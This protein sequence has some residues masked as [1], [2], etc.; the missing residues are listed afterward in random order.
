MS[1]ETLKEEWA[2]LIGKTF[3]IDYEIKGILKL[4]EWEYSRTHKEQILSIG[5]EQ[6]G[7][8]NGGYL[9]TNG[10]IEFFVHDIPINE[11]FKIVE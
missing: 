7:T 8:N 6:I 5:F 4:V 9:L 11:L 1:A 3:W 10:L 2:K